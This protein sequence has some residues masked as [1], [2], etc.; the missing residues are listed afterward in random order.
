MTVL[1]QD[2]DFNT[3]YT[4]AMVS[5]GHLEKF[6]DT[7]GTIR[8]RKLKD[9][10]YNGQEEKGKQLSTKLKIQQYY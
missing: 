10:L 2:P 6:E 7:K 9:I 1:N 5:F 3:L 8:S 4:I